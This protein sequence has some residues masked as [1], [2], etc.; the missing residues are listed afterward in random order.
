M[1]ARGGLTAAAMALRP[2][3][4]SRVI[5]SSMV[6]T[7]MVCWRR[8]LIGL[9][10]RYC[11]SR[12]SQTLW[13]PPD[14]SWSAFDRRPRSMQPPPPSQHGLLLAWQQRQQRPPGFL[15]RPL[16]HPTGHPSGEIHDGQEGHLVVVARSGTGKNRS[17]VMPW[18]LTHDGAALVVDIKGENALVCAR[19][20]RELG[21]QVH[22]FNP[23]GLQAMAFAERGFT[24]ARC[25]PIDELDPEHE[26]FAD[27][28]MTL[29]EDLAGPAPPNLP[30]PFWRS[31][32]LGLIAAAIAWVAWAARYVAGVPPE[33]RSLGGVWR[34]LCAHDLTY[35]LAVILDTHAQHARFTPY[36]H[37][38]FGN[39]LEAEEKVRMSIRSE[40]L[41]LMRV[42][43]SPRIQQATSA[44]D[45]KI[46]TLSDPEARDSIFVVMPAERLASHAAV[47]RV[48]LGRALMAIARRQTRPTQP[49]LI[50]L[51]ELAQIGPLPAVKVAVTLLRGF[52]A[53]VAICLQSVA[54]LR[55]MWPTDY[56]TIL[57]NS[58]LLNF[59]NAS[60]AAAHEVAQQL[61]DIDAT[62]LFA[63]GDEEMAVHLPGHRTFVARKLDYLSDAL[64][65]G[66]FDPSPYYTARRR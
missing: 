40:A 19:H 20:R 30:D 57:E 66:R 29:A 28:C 42:F 37:E 16:S 38:E 9:P 58:A 54:Q 33:D 53:K 35:R 26:D 2:L 34:L 1:A 3:L 64:F 18:L 49:T 17:C 7:S 15:A 63:L 24:P 22:V 52:G 45:F 46:A 50:V 11:T 8:R 10:H 44:S 43:S 55:G 65:K 23:F 47:L 14:A 5:R 31:G 41:S 61:G 60:E 32:A 51:D 27:D 59:G 56:A 21:Q 62:K 25:N 13:E 36:I 12:T 48:L 39:L 6:S 4:V